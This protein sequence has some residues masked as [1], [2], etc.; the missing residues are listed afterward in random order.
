MAKNRGSRS[1]KQE[2]KQRNKQSK[3][4]KKESRRIDKRNINQRN[5]SG[6]SVLR[7]AA[8]KTHKKSYKKSSR[9]AS[10]QKL[11][12]VMLSPPLT[13]TI[14]SYEYKAKNIPIKVTILKRK[15]EFVP[16]YEVSISSIS[17]TTEF[18]LERIR[19][20]LVKAVN[21]EMIDITD[22]KKSKLI[23]S[24]FEETIFT[25]GIRYFGYL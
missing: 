7:E 6:R 24:Q 8:T 3:Q 22:L 15:G 20:E 16:L 25:E 21:L 23:E 4:V 19:Q 11:S 9:Q 17:K 10:S 1:E 2:N 18:I 12:K 13:R 5:K 14:D